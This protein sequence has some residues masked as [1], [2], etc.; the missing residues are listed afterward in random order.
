M[1]SNALTA[2][3]QLIVATPFIPTILNSAKIAVSRWLKYLVAPESS[4]KVMDGLAKANEETP[5]FEI[6]PSAP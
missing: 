6:Y 5:L 2:K 4:L 1:S 3:S